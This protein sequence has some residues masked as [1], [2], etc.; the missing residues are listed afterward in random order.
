MPVGTITGRLRLGMA[1][2]RCTS[3]LGGGAIG[4]L[5]AAGLLSTARAIRL[6]RG[7]PNPFPPTF[8]HRELWHGAVVRGNGLVCSVLPVAGFPYPG[9]APWSAA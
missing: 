2:L 7:R 4:L 6:Q 1:K 8:G 3:S 9:F 5:I